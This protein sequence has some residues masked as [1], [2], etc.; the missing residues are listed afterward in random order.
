MLEFY[1]GLA[2]R[3]YPFRFLLWLLASV[4]VAVFGGAVFLSNEE[5]Y[6]LGSITFLLWILLLISFTYT[7]MA[8]LPVVDPDARLT[9]RLTARLRRGLLWL[10]A[11]SLTLLCC[12]AA[13]MSFRAVSILL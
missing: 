11:V 7:F 1:N 6:T 4:A 12:A 5:L 2:K 8:P 10:L 13:F 3:I 9:Q